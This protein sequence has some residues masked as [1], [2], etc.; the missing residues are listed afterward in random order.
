M[1]TPAA[2]ATTIP[3]EETGTKW[4]R[5]KGTGCQFHEVLYS[6]L[7]KHQH[8]HYESVLKNIK[9]GGRTIPEAFLMTSTVYFLVV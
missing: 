9:I 1:G 4:K 5:S 8:L 2:V 7:T 3:E 6:D